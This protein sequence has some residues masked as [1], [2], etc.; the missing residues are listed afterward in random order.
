M[1]AR[2]AGPRTRSLLLRHLSTPLR[3]AA[4]E[5]DEEIAADSE[6]MAGA[7]EQALTAQADR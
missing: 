6:A 4:T 7:A 5:V 3:E 2:V 1:A